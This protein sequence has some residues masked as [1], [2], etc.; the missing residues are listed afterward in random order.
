[1]SSVGWRLGSA[2]PV[3]AYP[4]AASSAAAHAAAVLSEENRA[5]FSE[6]PDD[7]AEQCC[8]GS[9][10]P[11]VF[12]VAPRSPSLSREGSRVFA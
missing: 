8:P 3:P 1:M 6:L 10:G 7:R 9:A 2:W 12:H 4:V 5:Q 11:E